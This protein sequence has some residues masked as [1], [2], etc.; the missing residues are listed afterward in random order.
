MLLRPRRRD[1]AQE[2]AAD[3]IGRIE[4]GPAYGWT[5][6]PQEP[7]GKTWPSYRHDGRRTGASSNEI[8]GKL[9]RRWKVGTRE[10]QLPHLS[11]PSPDGGRAIAHVLATAATVETPKLFFPRSLS[12]KLD[13]QTKGYRGTFHARSVGM[14]R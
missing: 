4:R 5:E 9:S 6:H 10:K 13:L 7:S 1:R 8:P 14:R 3:A 11:L 12:P 2:P